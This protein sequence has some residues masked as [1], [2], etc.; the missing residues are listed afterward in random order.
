MFSDA[1][2]DQVIFRKIQR[3]RVDYNSYPWPSISAS[4]KD[5]VRRMLDMNPKT[6]ITA[7]E[8]LSKYMRKCN[9]HFNYVLIEE[10]FNMFLF[11][12]ELVV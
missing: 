5:L 1:E 6:R 10:E 11:C 9:M 4:A 7:L 8:V 3:G 2:T 12:A